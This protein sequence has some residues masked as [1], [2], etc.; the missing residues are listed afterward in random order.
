V[1]AAL[2]P[3]AYV[4]FREPPPPAAEPMRFQIPP[5]EKTALAFAGGFAV[6]PDGRKLVFTAAGPDNMMQLWV[7]ALDSIEARP[8][9]STECGIGTAPFWSPDSRF[10]VFDAGG[11]LKKIDVSGGPAQTLCAAPP[12][13]AGG[14]WNRDGVL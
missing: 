13:L 10:V 3:V 7:R 12:P 8:L 2:T 14:S 5:P 1:A 9:A 11:K 6:S 4:H